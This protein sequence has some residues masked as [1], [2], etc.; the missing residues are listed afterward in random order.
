MVTALAYEG[1]GYALW[2]GGWGFGVFGALW[3]ALG[4]HAYLGDAFFGLGTGYRP[5][6]AWVAFPYLGYRFRLGEG[7]EAQLRLQT[8]FRVSAE[9]GLEDFF[10]LVPNLLDLT[11]GFPL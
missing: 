3:P 10:G 8:P 1:E 6:D 11:L 2:L 4:A 7:V 5:G 9:R